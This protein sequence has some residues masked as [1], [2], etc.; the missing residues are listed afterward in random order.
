[1]IKMENEIV[2]ENLFQFYLCRP[3]TLLSSFFAVMSNQFVNFLNFISNI[4]KHNILPTIDLRI[5][6]L[7]VKII[8]SF[9]VNTTQQR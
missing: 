8:N 3:P 2:N 4:L 5:Y 1:M 7:I 6:Q 9:T